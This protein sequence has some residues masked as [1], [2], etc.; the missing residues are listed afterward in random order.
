M[1]GTVKTPYGLGKHLDDSGGII[2]VKYTWGCGYLQ[3]NQVDTRHTFVVTCFACTPSKFELDVPLNISLDAL[4]ELII[5]KIGKPIYKCNVD[6]LQ[7]T[8]GM[9]CVL[10]ERPDCI[11]TTLR[12]LL[13]CVR[14]PFEFDKMAMSL[15]VETIPFMEPL[16]STM[17]Q[18]TVPSIIQITRGNSTAFGS[19]NLKCGRVYWEIEVDYIGHGDVH[20]GIG[21]Q[22]MPL[23][24][25]VASTG[26]FW[27]YT[28]STGKKTHTMSEPFG[29]KCKNEDI[30]GV[31]YDAE[32]GTLSFYHNKTY[33]GIAFRNIYTQKLRP[34]FALTLS[35]QRLTLLPNRTLPN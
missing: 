27:G 15:H 2:R 25:N 12:P 5:E 26:L 18:F 3:Q 31:L 33:L 14:T 24:V 1:D 9:K 8:V 21:S 17:E 6:I 10:I 4:R 22:D 23:N 11:F 19:V 7:P 16:Q 29:P 35:G 32:F 13:V 28:L 20:I 30:V 34:V